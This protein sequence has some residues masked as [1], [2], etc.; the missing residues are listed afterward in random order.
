[1]TKSMFKTPVVKHVKKRV[2]TDKQKKRKTQ[3][4]FVSCLRPSVCAFTACLLY[5]AGTF[6]GTT[7]ACQN[8]GDQTHR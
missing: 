3:N 1:M 4:R 8:N 5:F 6:A 7:E 2:E